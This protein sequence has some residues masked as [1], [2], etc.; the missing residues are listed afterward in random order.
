MRIYFTN[1]YIRAYRCNSHYSIFNFS[2]ILFIPKTLQA[3]ALS[4]SL[5]KHIL[6]KCYFL[7][8][9]L[10]H[11]CGEAVV[12]VNANRTDRQTDKENYI[13]F[14]LRLL[15]EPGMISNS[16]WSVDGES[17][18][19]AG[20][21]KSLVSG[22]MHLFIILTGKVSKKYKNWIIIKKILKAKSVLFSHRGSLI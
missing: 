18:F 13:D 6:I 16:W 1:I 15:G 20:S 4:I 5:K 9:L 8:G 2:L 11:V 21:N 17:W 12:N 7:P 14:R 3:S 10:F 22:K 19:C